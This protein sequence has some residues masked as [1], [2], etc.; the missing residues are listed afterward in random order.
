MACSKDLPSAVLM[1]S[2]ACEIDRHSGRRHLPKPAWH[3]TLSNSKAWW[4][5]SWRIGISSPST[6]QATLR[7][8]ESESVLGAHEGVYEQ[9]RTVRRAPVLCEC[10]Q[11][12]IHSY[13]GMCEGTSASANHKP[14][15]SIC[16]I[17]TRTGQNVVATHGTLALAQ[18]I[19]D[20]DKDTSTIVQL[21][22][23]NRVQR[24]TG[25]KHGAVPPTSVHVTA[26]REGRT[27]S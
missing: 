11:H 2:S 6:L 4:H 14:H 7:L 13:K 24:Y 21:I 19:A 20:T 5:R 8:A 15:G 23:R 26:K 16:I 3:M 12:S 1:S 10:H 25:T 22:K 9:T 27:W 17:S 18:L